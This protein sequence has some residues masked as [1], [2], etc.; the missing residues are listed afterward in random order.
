[1]KS[2]KLLLIVNDFDFFLSHRL[3]LALAAKER[4]F[5]VH[6]AVAAKDELR[7][8]PHGIILHRFSLSR[9]GKTIFKEIRTFF[10]IVF[11]LSRLQPDVL[12]LVTIKPV[13]YGG[14]A[15]RIVGIHAVV[16]AVTGL[17]SVFIAQG[18]LA[19]FFRFL[20]NRFYRIALERP[21]SKI[22]FQNPDDQDM[23]V[24]AG[25]VS[26]ENTCLIRGSGVDLAQYSV[27]PEPEGRC[28]VV[29]V[30]R[31]LVDKGVC[32]F[33]EAAR[34]LR[35]RNVDVTFRVIGDL[36]PDNPA[37]VTES[38]LA[39]WRQEGVVEF[40]GYRK[41]IAEQYAASHIACLPS[42]REGLPK[43]L[44]E[45]AA[46]G[47]A[48]ITTD[49]P[50]CRY[51]IEPGKTGLLIPSRDAVAL[52]DAI[53]YLVNNPQERKNMGKNGRVL[54]EQAFGVGK[55]IEAHME[56]YRSLLESTC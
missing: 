46:C 22:I 5:D 48:V 34:I 11:L 27:Q 13:L 56:I 50:G 3:V 54:A 44:I 49:V 17:G 28:V 1:M 53:E 45:A 21:G 6:V 37:A 40:L 9:S 38:A 25:L 23:F 12:H 36:D 29:M 18:K 55:V 32:E 10:S 47:R 35:K 26:R 52:A 24:K 14:L 30:S 41:D 16:F 2:K 20:V 31:L 19:S 39:E 42:Y 51:V 8:L 33:V 15:S 7:S 43:S 4:G